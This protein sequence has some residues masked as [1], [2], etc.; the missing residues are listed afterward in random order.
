LAWIPLLD[1]FS[2]I[3]MPLAIF[4]ETN[5]RAPHL[6]ALNPV[7]VH[8]ITVQPLF[9]FSADEHSISLLYDDFNKE[10]LI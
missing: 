1:A 10:P 8:S 2:G 5:L 7:P 3:Y 9:L 6:S 4:W